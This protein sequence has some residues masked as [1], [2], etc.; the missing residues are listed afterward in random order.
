M[1]KAN[2]IRK[3]LVERE[4][5]LKT[6]MRTIVTGAATEER[7]LTE[8]EAKTLGELK[9]RVAG[10]V[11]QVDL[12]DETE[13]RADQH[14]AKVSEVVLSATQ[15]EM[16]QHR[17]GGEENVY[18]P[19]NARMHPAD[20]GRGFLQDVLTTRSAEVTEEAEEARARL[21]KHQKQMRHRGLSFQPGDVP[22]SER[23]QTT[24]LMKGLVPP[25]YIFA[26]A[27]P[28][29]RRA[30]PTADAM[31]N[32]PMPQ[33]GMTL[34]IPRVTGTGATATVVAENTAA[35]ETDAVVTDL[36]IPVKIINGAIDLSFAAMHRG[37][38]VDDLLM[39]DLRLAVEEQINLQVV[40]KPTPAT[41]DID[42]L[43]STATNR[44]TIA[45]ANYKQD[46]DDSNV[47]AGKTFAAIVSNVLTKLATSRY[48]RA[49]HLIMHPRR[50]GYLASA[51]DT[52]GRPLYQSLALTAA[53]VVAHG[54]Q[55]GAVNETSVMLA[56][57]PVIADPAIPADIDTSDEDAVIGFYSPE[58]LLYESPMMVF[59]GN[60]ALHKWTHTITMG[61]YVGFAPKYDVSAAAVRGTIFAAT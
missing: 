1:A 15:S 14:A 16:Q 37:V 13:H 54:D 59:S 17:T 45:A 19:G 24:A 49:T 11:D 60:P 48:Q 27:A 31:N 8:T 3:T 22:V 47:T 12:I 56:G 30:R 34:I 29:I 2:E 26:D 39:L 9:A 20:G 35:S 25:Q 10:I 5:A 61:K 51:L 55:G 46:A 28:A 50:L 23:D 18:H 36:E 53:N 21:L 42:G 38:M 40:G 52:Q 43:L 32:R 7:E 6:E 4:N 41:A 57:V 44:V 58:M 33:T